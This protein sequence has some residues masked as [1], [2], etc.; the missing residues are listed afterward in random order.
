MKHILDGCSISIKEEV[1]LKDIYC[2]EC[3][4]ILHERAAQK[5]VLAYEYLCDVKRQR[6][7][8]AFKAVNEEVKKRD[9]LRASKA[10]KEATSVDM[11]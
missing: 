8:A 10:W 1:L 6:Y 11:E 5:F 7:E 9:N 3:L 4:E 2:E